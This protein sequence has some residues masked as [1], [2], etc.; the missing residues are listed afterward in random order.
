MGKA[1]L[2]DMIYSFTTGED[3]KYG[4]RYKIASCVGRG[5]TLLIVFI[6]S[7]NRF[8]RERRSEV[9]RERTSVKWPSVNE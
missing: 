2:S 7:E 5:S 1:G 6:F 8:R 9:C 3:R 4:N